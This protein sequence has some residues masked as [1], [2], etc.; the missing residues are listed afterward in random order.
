MLVFRLIS[1][2]SDYFPSYGYELIGI[3]STRVVVS[4]NSAFISNFIAEN[5]LNSEK[6]GVIF[7]STGVL[8]VLI[9]DC[10]FYNCQALDGGVVYFDTTSGTIAV[11]RVCGNKCKATE[12]YQFGY[13]YTADTQK[14]MMD[15]FTLAKI[16]YKD[17]SQYY[18]VYMKNG[19]CQVNNFNYSMNSVHYEAI[20]FDLTKTPIMSFSNL[21]SNI[22]KSST[23]LKLNSQNGPAILRY[24]NILNSQSKTNCV[25]IQNTANATIHDCIFLKNYNYT[26]R[27]FSSTVYMRS[28]YLQIGLGTFDGTSFSLAN[29]KISSTGTLTRPITHIKSY[30]CHA[31][32]PYV[33]IQLP[34]PTLKNTI[35]PTP[36]I[37]LQNTKARTP[38][39]T[40]IATLKNTFLPTP[41]ISLPNTKARTFET[42]P[43]YSHSPTLHPSLSNTNERTPDY[44]I[45]P[46][47]QITYDSTPSVTLPPRT[48]CIVYSYIIVSKDS[49]HI[50][51]IMVT[52]IALVYC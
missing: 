28:C 11:N 1:A 44:S 43:K 35:L 27:A 34:I 48:H 4:V 26:F 36:V 5:F 33:G 18:S 50:F 39:V 20:S 16:E 10:G 9:E 46:T 29:N 23:V 12:Y 25:F 24:S 7:V 8:R 49:F 38:G 52:L 40:P 22:Q 19:Q 42:T 51:P 17:N 21:D 30:R 37:S 31:E 41:V 15:Y 14:I 47:Q 3:S 2:F 13:F 32:I 6:G 45:H